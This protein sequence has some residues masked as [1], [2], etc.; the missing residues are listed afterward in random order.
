MHDCKQMKFQIR[1]N[2]GSRIVINSSTLLKNNVKARMW[3]PR[4]I[5]ESVVATYW[6]STIFLTVF[7]LIIKGILMKK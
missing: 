3:M 5:L 4:Y 1:V 6:F 7:L 2:V